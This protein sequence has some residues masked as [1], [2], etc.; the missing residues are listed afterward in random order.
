MHLTYSQD[1]WERYCPEVLKTPLH[2]GP[3][4]GGAREGTKYR[5]WYENTLKSYR[6]LFGEAPPADIWPDTE[7]RF[8][9][10]ENFQRVNTGDHWIVR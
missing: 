5:D 9:N 8:R 7:A 3:T 2:H 1:Y 6:R 10:V 4:R